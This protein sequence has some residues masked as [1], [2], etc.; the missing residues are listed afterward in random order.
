MDPMF[1]ASLAI[2]A[3]DHA[4]LMCDYNLKMANDACKRLRDVGAFYDAATVESQMYARFG[5][6]MERFDA[7]VCPTVLT[8]RL[9]A[10]FS[11]ATDDYVVDGKTQEL[12]LGISTCH[13]F[14]MMGRCPAISVPSGIGDNGV[15]TGLQIAS[16]AYNDIEVFRIAAAFEGS[17]DEP[18][19][20][21]EQE[22]S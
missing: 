4:E 8:N 3:E 20:P 5:A 12:D 15:P 21:A 10:D 6:L 17:W 1:F 14:N 2:S 13:I 18:F 19:R 16:R 22:R 7:L 11:P 9:N